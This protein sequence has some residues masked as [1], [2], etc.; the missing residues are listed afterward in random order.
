LKEGGLNPRL[1]AFQ[2]VPEF[3]N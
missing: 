3:F 2:P 1:I